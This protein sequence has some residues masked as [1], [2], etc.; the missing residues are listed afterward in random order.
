MKDLF[1]V[2]LL[3]TVFAFCSCSNIENNKN[4]QEYNRLEKAVKQASQDTNAILVETLFGYNTAMN[5]EDIIKRRDEIRDSVDSFKR[6]GVEFV[7]GEDWYLE[8][9]EDEEIIDDYL[10]VF[11]HRQGFDVSP[12]CNSIDSLFDES[13]QR[14][15]FSITKEENAHLFLFWVKNN[16]VS[17][18][19][20]EYE[21]NH[22]YLNYYD[23]PSYNSK[24][25][26]PL[27]NDL[28]KILFKDND[29]ETSPSSSK[30]NK[31]KVENSSWDGSVYQVKKYVKKH[32]KD[33]SSY[34]SIKWGK[35]QQ[36]GNEYKVL[37]TYRAKNSFGAYVIE[38]GVFTLDMNGNVI[39][40]EKVE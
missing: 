38:G 1:K 12:F 2:F 27:Y 4:R 22:S 40:F 29:K 11:T 33:P 25:N 3:L 26:T 28:S 15:K 10:F 16:I 21:S 19:S 9:K 23:V 34:E 20:Y 8:K 14:F 17:K 37:H 36:N 32:L 39:G 18:F 6:Q 5:K 31:V 13:W 35:V 7:S 30:M 24:Y